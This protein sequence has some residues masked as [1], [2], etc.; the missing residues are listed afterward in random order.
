MNFILKL[1]LL[2]FFT[3]LAL[4]TDALVNVKTFSTAKNRTTKVVT[5]TST[6]TSKAR[7]TQISKTIVK[8]T[9]TIKATNSTAKRTTATTFSTTTTTTTTK[10]TTSTTITTTTTKPTT[11]TTTT[12]KISPNSAVPIC[13]MLYGYNVTSGNVT[14][15]VKD[16]SGNSRPAYEVRVI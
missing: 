4:E 9:T 7:V 1:I 16:S 13:N 8:N 6:T 10:T 14:I 2:A 11:A 15:C 5:K 12:A 3:C